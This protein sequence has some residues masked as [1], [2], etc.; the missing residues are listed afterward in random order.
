MEPV[1][2]AIICAVAFGGVVALSAFIRQLIVS[3]DKKLNDAAQQKAL[4]QELE[5]LNK[6][7]SDM[8]DSKRFD[9]HYKVLGANKDAIA[10][11]DNKIDDI[12][13]KKAQLIER[14]GQSIAK[15]S[16][17]ILQGDVSIDRKEACDKLRVELDKKLAVYDEELAQLQKRRASLWDSHHDLEVYLLNQE[18]QRNKSLDTIYQRHTAMLEKVYMRHTDQAEHVAVDSIK[19][20]NKSFKMMVMAPIQ[21]LM[22]FFGLSQGVSLDQVLKETKARSEVYDMQNE[23]NRSNH[24]NQSDVDSDDE[25]DDYNDIPQTDFISSRKRELAFT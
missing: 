3:R 12:M 24:V 9:A 21:F 13:Q 2:I 25:Y 10:Y 6:M 1:T 20:G 18:E 15:E 14:Y 5:G 7:R 11:I 19:A 4:K 23:I 16:G 22:S 8:E 17:S